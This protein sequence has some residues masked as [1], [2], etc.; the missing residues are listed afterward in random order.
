MNIFH[1]KRRALGHHA[2]CAD[3]PDYSGVNDAARE[4][5]AIAREALNYYRERD[6]QNRPLLEEAARVAMDT[7][8]Q[9]QEIARQNAD[10]STDYWNYQKDTFRPLEQ[11]IVADAQNYDTTARRDAAAAEGVADV[12]MQAEAARQAQTRQQQRMGV[13]PSSGKAMA[14]QGQMGLAEAAAKAGAANSGRDKVELQGYARRMDA[15]NL[16]RGLASSQATSAGVALNAGNSAVGNAGVPLSQA[17]QA[18]S[19]MGQ[20]FNTAIQGNNSAGNLFGQAAQMQGQD[21]GLFGALGNIA[22]QFAG[23]AAGSTMLAGL[24]DKNAKK[25]IKKV[26]DEKALEAVEKTPV[27]SW[28]YKDGQGDGGAHVGPMAQ[29]VQKNMGEKAAPGGKMVDLVSLNGTNMA[30]IAALS[31][32]VDKLT[33]AVEGAAA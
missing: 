27:S 20:G 17:N 3:A 11:G 5:A 24:S 2:S 8:R 30:A 7:S 32:K 15:A 26:S 21:S 18:T 25:D 12:G 6:Q 19:M 14:L 10:I 13:N 29:H 22:G 23:S 4:N 16:G 1:E 9:Q 28:K 33:K 31:R